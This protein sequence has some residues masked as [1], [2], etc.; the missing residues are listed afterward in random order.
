M[1]NTSFSAMIEPLA[2]A[3]QRAKKPLMDATIR[4]LLRYADRNTPEKSGVLRRGNQSD[5]VASGDYGRVFNQVPY[6]GFVHNG[7][8]P[9]VIVPKR[10]GGVL[11]FQ[12]GG[13]TIF[14]KRV[15]HPGTNANPFY[16][17][18]VQQSD[19]ERMALLQRTGDTIVARS[20]G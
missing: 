16:D 18:A 9:H 17:R 13:K 15:N 19:D 6:A 10:P 7:T 1:T 11:V 2:L 3:V 12:I 20:R 8:P 14:T 4:I 5:V